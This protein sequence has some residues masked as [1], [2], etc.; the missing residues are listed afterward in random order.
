MT[1]TSRIIGVWLLSLVVAVLGIADPGWAQAKSE[2]T[3]GLSGLASETL[4]PPVAGHFVKYYLALMFDYLVGSKD[5]VVR[6][7]G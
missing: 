7:R 1:R 5:Y 3:I 6:R 4:D 2:L